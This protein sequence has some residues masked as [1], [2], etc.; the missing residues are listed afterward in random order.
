[1]EN[2]NVY[3]AEVISEKWIVSNGEIDHLIDMLTHLKEEHLAK[4]FKEVILVNCKDVQAE[5]FV[6]PFVDTPMHTSFFV[7]GK[8]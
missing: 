4:G 3:T 6:E 1:M 7:L 8:R 2:E 5:A